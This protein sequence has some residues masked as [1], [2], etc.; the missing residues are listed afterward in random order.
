MKR[1]S[2]LFAAILFLSA[3]AVKG[4]SIDL[5]LPSIGIGTVGGHHCPP[6]QAKKG[7]C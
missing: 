6:G 5:K 2:L 7:R 3:C 1:F 4:P